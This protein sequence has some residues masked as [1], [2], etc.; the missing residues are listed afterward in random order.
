MNMRSVKPTTIETGPV[1][2]NSC[3]HTVEAEIVF[4]R[5]RPYVN[6]GQKCPRCSSS[7]DAAFVLSYDRAA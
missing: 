1:H 6:P 5:K 3:T 4:N 2:C 7:L